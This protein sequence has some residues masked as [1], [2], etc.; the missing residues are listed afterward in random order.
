VMLTTHYMDE[1]QVLCQRLAI[2]DH[3]QLVAVDTPQNLV[4]RLQATY[5]VKLVLTQAL[6]GAQLEAL[7]GL[8]AS[9]QALEGNTYILRLDKTPRALD[10]ALDAIVQGNISLEHL[11]V[12]P[13]TLED[14]FL[15]LTGTELRD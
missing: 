1:A 9:V 4:G 8:A 12:A 11:E 13:V 3:G 5:T 10:K 6:N 2:M 15:E 7:Q 14:V